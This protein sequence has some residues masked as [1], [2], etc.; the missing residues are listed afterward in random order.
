MN[1]EQVNP[2]VIEEPAR[3]VAWKDFRLALLGAGVLVLLI[4]LSQWLWFL[5]PL[6]L[7][8]GLAYV[9]FVPGY[10]LTAAL[11]PREDDIDGIERI[12]LSLGLSVAWVSVLALILDWL[13]WGL[14]LWPIVLGELL[15]IL[16]FMA[17]ALWRRSR[18]PAAEAYAPDLAWRPRPWWREL[19]QF[20]RRIY[21]L[22]A[23]ALLV[24]GLAAAWV[25]LVPSPSQFM[26]EFYMLGAEGLAESFP[27]EAAVG[28]DLGVTLGI[29]NRER[30]AASYRVEVWAVDPWTAGRR[31]LVAQDGP[32]PLAVGNGREWPIVWQ[33]PWAGDDQV[34]DL[35]LFTG[36]A[37]EPY[38]SLRLW[39]NVTE[40]LPAPPAQTDA[41][42][43]SASLPPP[44]ASLPLT[45]TV[46]PIAAST[47][48][49]TAAPTAP[50][51]TPTPSPAPPAGQ[52][53]QVIAP[54][55]ANLR[56]E[57]RVDGEL[58]ASVAQGTA[59]TMTAVSADGL[60]LQVCC[61]AGL[62]VDGAWVWR[63]LV[64]E[65]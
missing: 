14:R 17:V 5:Q 34:V 2:V 16:A 30:D 27:R 40:P 60:W 50:A 52:V 63:E 44:A 15:S 56:A 10:C 58:L 12:G 37:T 29:M 1:A 51:A 61:V 54:T 41:A 20:E 31:E 43:V 32:Y 39:L 62:E 13:P 6:R 8:L 65:P 47:S 11:F 36:D 28:E 18:L 33:M 7:A 24:A 9:L 46:T 48:T 45:A 42:A 53:V 35:L 19:P 49:P 3:R 4:A 23:A 38:R 57:A 21:G 55:G 25:F 59:L 26:T 22:V 64:A